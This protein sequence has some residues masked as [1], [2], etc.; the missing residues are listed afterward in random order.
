MSDFYDDL[1]QWDDVQ[2]QPLPT[3]ADFP[4]PRCDC[5]CVKVYEQM[6]AYPSTQGPAEYRIECVC[7][8]RSCG[9]REVE[10]V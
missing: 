1:D 3:Y 4:C 10:R 7:D 6:T 8:D 9:W 2:H 5:R